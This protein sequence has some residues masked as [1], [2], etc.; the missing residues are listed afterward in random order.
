M[1]WDDR[2]IDSSHWNRTHAQSGLPIKLTKIA[3]VTHLDHC[4][5]WRCTDGRVPMKQDGTT[6]LLIPHTGT[7]H[8]HKVACLSGV[9]RL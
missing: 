7:V 3:Q 2:F 4:A 9:I 6:G 5:V 8:T 1:K